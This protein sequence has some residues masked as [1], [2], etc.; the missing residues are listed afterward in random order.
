VAIEVIFSFLG[1]FR[2]F[3]GAC[4]GLRDRAVMPKSPSF[5]L[6]DICPS[7]LRLALPC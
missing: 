5:V 6:V 7:L 3:V 4:Y 1:H 2:R